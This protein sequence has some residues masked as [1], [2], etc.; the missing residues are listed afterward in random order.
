MWGFLLYSTTKLTKPGNNIHHLCAPSGYFCECYT[1]SFGC[2]LYTSI[3]LSTN[4]KQSNCHKRP[5]F[6][7]HSDPEGHVPP[8]PL[9][10]PMLGSQPVNMYR[11]FV[12]SRGHMPPFPPPDTHAGIRACKYVYIICYIQ[13][14]HAP[15]PPS[16]HPCYD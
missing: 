16:G 10:T 5:K 2:P 12:I 15:L 11:L 7:K 9:Q 13:G 6:Y 14:A 1:K 8:F 3:T 4:S